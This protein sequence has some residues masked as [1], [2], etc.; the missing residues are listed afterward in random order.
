MHTPHLLR[1]QVQ[2]HVYFSTSF[3][4]ILKMVV[5]FCCAY[6][7]GEFSVGVISPVFA[8]KAPISTSAPKLP[9]GNCNR[10]FRSAATEQ[11]GHGAGEPLIINSLSN[12][13]TVVGLM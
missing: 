12:V 11:V 9:S 13:L 7:K 3:L 1:D 6:G 10:I 5:F 8:L 4:M 2:L